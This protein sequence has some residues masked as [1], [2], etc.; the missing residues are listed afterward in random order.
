LRRNY[1]W[2]LISKQ[3]LEKIPDVDRPQLKSV[4]QTIVAAN[5]LPLRIEGK[6]TF[7]LALDNVTTFVQAV[8][9]D[10]KVDGILGLDFLSDTN[11]I[12]DMTDKTLKIDGKIYFFVSGRSSW[13][14]S[15]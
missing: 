14:L 4:K 8:V 7:Q 6:G 2:T 5:D 12:I 13:L 11:G 9:V 1:W 3:F 10:I 15:S